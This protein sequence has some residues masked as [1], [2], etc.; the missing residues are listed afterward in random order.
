M[1]GHVTV[2]LTFLYARVTCSPLPTSSPLSFA[3]F[4]PGADGGTTVIVGPGVDS[5]ASFYCSLTCGFDKGRRAGRRRRDVA[6]DCYRSEQFDDI[7]PWFLCYRSELLEE[8]DVAFVVKS[9]S[10]ILKSILLWFIPSV[11]MIFN[12]GRQNSIW[13]FLVPFFTVVFL[14]FSGQSWI[15]KM[16]KQGSCFDQKGKIRFWSIKLALLILHFFP[17]YKEHIR[18]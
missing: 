9:K 10:G 7:V 5:S 13:F 8:E 6:G 14:W 17:P 11:V 18:W 3:C 15:F 1:W 2:R 4:S 12:Q 16:K